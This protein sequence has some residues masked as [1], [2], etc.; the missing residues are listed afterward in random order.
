MYDQAAVKPVIIERL[1]NGEFLEDICTNEGMPTSRAVR[2]WLINDADF[3]RQCA[4]ARRAEPVPDTAAGA[5][6][7]A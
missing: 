4:K 5:A 6:R 7:G 1:A 3:F 2:H